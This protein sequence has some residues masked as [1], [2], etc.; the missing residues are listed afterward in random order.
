[1]T[2]M[3][4]AAALSLAAILPFTATSTYAE[5]INSQAALCRQAPVKAAKTGIDCTTTSAINQDKTAPAKQ[6]PN[7]P[8]NYGNGIVF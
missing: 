6:Y 7:G 5:A 4:L 2:K 8:V 1:M 3:A